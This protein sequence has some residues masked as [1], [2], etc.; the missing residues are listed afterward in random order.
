MLLGKAAVTAGA[1]G[2]SQ[3][4]AVGGFNLLITH[5]EGRPTSMLANYFH[6]LQLFIP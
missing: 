6:D 4:P 1:L 5:S 3:S 2:S